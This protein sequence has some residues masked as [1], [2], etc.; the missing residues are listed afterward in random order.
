MKLVSWLLCYLD[1]FEQMEI[2]IRY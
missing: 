1:T 2:F